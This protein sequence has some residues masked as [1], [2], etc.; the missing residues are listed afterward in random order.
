MTLVVLAA[1]MGSR[2]KGL[3]QV[4][5]ISRAGEFIIDFSVYDA[6][7]SGFNKVVF[8]IKR[9]LYDTFRQTI[10]KRLE[11]YVEV[12]YVFQENQFLDGA[13]VPPDRV[14]PFGTAH[15][16]L[17][18][19]GEVNE[20]FVVINA[21]DFYGADAFRCVA[22]YLQN[23]PYDGKCHF[24]MAGYVLDNTL[25]KSGYV[26]RGEC[27]VDASGYLT[28][29]TERTKICED[30]DTVKYL[31]GEA[32]KPI[33]RETTVSM[34]FFGFTPEILTYIRDGFL[35]FIHDPA[36]DLAKAEY[37]LP[38]A[39]TQMLRDGLC[40]IRVLHTSAK[41]F[42]VTYPEDKPAVAEEIDKMISSGIYPDGLWK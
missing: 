1:G 29:I 22:E 6:I 25:S 8:I 10:G 24:C 18:C 41:W 7:R 28:G 35:R 30:G 15:A 9:D 12:R 23:H 42:G 2:Y 32:W 36:T 3:K 26:S 38:H 27:F 16:L 17:A 33:P 13:P 40:D 11:R 21:D 20:P 31:D 37:Y 34:N 39:V 5:P 4:D 19:L 14:K